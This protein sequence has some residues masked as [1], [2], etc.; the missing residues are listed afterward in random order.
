MLP[1]SLLSTHFHTLFCQME[2]QIAMVANRSEKHVLIINT[3]G[4]IGMRDTSSGL[5]PEAGYLQK[6][7]GEMSELRRTSIPSFEIKEYEPLLDSSDMTPSG[8]LQIAADIAERYDEFD[9]FVVLHGTDTM[10][11]SSSALSF[12]LQGLA[13]PV[14]FTGAQ[15]PLGEVRNDARENLKTAIL[16]AADSRIQE[17]ALFFGEHLLRGCRATKMSATKLDAFESPNY[18]PIGAA[19]STIEV[20]ERRLLVRPESGPLRV[21]PIHDREVATF[22]LFPGMSIEILRNLLRRPLKALVLRSYGVGNGPASNRGFI[23]CLREAC[24]MGTTIVNLTQ[25]FHGG[26][27]QTSYATGTALR[28]AGVVSGQ[29]MTIEAAITKLMFLLSQDLEPEQLRA[30]VSTD[31]VGELTETVPN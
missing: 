7:V 8:W 3:G 11:Y 10:A 22:H 9:G 13:K 19:E 25:C 26:V 29:D 28:D 4:T 17:V 20:F 12:M 16:L 30:Q 6:L 27:K 14:I 31:L 24:E 23:E 5:Q 1:K 2:N 21:E 18:S 15:L